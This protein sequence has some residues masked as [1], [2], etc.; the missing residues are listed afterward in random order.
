MGFVHSQLSAALSRPTTSECLPAVHSNTIRK[1]PGLWGSGVLYRFQLSCTRD[2]FAF[3][4]KM[5]VYLP[6]NDYDLPNLDLLTLLF[7]K[8]LH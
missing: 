2:R 1:H 7:G 6:E 3:V 5:P 8:N 4:R